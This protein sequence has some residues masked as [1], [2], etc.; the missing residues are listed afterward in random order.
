M[1]SNVLITKGL[2]VMEQITSNYRLTVR[3]MCRLTVL[4]AAV[5]YALNS[6]IVTPL[7]IQFA[8]DIVY[9]DAWWV[10][11]L[12]YLTEEGLLDLAVFAVCYPAAIYAVWQA[13]LKRAVR[14]PVAFALLTLARFVV[15]FFM[16]AITDS[17]LP[18]VDEF[19]SFDLP[20][21]GALYLL[22]MLQYALVIALTL[23]VK[24]R[25]LRK[26]EYA[27]AE[28]LLDGREPAPEAPL[29]P[30]TRL[31]SVKN[32]LQCLALLMGLLMTV[33]RVITHQ[34]YQYTLF[35]QN[36]MT[37]GLAVMVLDLISDIFVGVILYFAA[38]LLISR[39]YRKDA[40]AGEA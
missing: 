36:G 40:E 29:L 8:S 21:I 32:P 19:L 15:N 27:E 35:T 5:L 3:R 37:D 11:I 13:G 14:V 30:F 38:L 16:T 31:V 18:D 2:S 1:N 33:L 39:F 12:Y 24:H 20:Y 10:Y 17:A 7:Y 23:A 4:V 34:I 28:A 22:E 6:F 26:R 25:Y 9:A